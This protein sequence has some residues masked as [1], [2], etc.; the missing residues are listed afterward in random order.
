MVRPL[1]A[2]R[3][4]SGIYVERPRSFRLD[5]RR[6]VRASA[7]GQCLDWERPA[8]A[9]ITFGEGPG[10]PPVVVFRAVRAPH[11]GRSAS[12]R[13]GRLRHPSGEGGA[14]MGSGGEV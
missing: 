5:G 7:A 9:A 8:F 4:G 12:G 13:E 2:W 10:V 6:A 3:W 1:R 11:P 14:M